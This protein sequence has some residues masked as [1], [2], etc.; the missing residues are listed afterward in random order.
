MTEILDAPIAQQLRILLVGDDAAEG[1][2][3]R[4][5]LE[6]C[7]DTRFQTHAARG[8]EEAAR[9]IKD[10]LFDAVLLDLSLPD[11]WG[12]ETLVRA[13]VMAWTVPVIVLVGSDQEDLA[14]KALRYGAQDFLIKHESDRMTVLRTLRSA[15]ERHRLLS[16][17]T[18]ARRREYFLANHDGLT[19]LPNRA[20]FQDQLGRVL[21]YASRNDKQLA[22]LFIDLNDFKRINDDLG[23]HVG[24]EILKAVGERV[25]NTVRRSD[26]S[27]RLGGDEFVV[28]AQDVLREG[29]PAV[30]A[31]KL[32]SALARPYLVGGQ[33]LSL[34]ASIG[35]AVFPRDGRNAATLI[36]HADA[37]MYRA[38][39]AG[40]SQYRFHLDE[41]HDPVARDPAGLRDDLEGALGRKEMVVHYERRV[42]SATGQLLAVE[43]LLRWRH[44]RRGL[45]DA[46]EFMP[47]AQG[48]G[49]L[50]QIGEWL[51]RRAC[52]DAMRWS[53]VVS[54]GVRVAVSVSLRQLRQKNFVATLK[55]CLRDSGLD[56]RRLE[57]GISENG[58]NDEPGVL[59]TTLELLRKL[60]VRVWIDDFGAGRF[61]LLDLEG[62]GAV[63]VK[64]DRSIVAGLGCDASKERVAEALIALARR[65]DLEV[66]AA[67]VES[68]E[69]LALLRRYGCELVQGALFGE[70]VPAGA[71]F[72]GFTPEPDPARAAPEGS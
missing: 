9:R 24:D 69:Q 7:D 47:A 60:G 37:A 59:R 35:I 29:D 46:E 52:E 27:A 30:V 41:G 4:Q 39:A 20:Y 54:R 11:A 32:V 42:H 8:F 56:A 51:L 22:I 36:R 61:S 34:S 50:L 49:V 19:G 18:L 66:G 10:E 55:G 71:S 64:L 53:E 3:L 68:A 63:G 13:R 5:L 15:I 70:P 33:E 43:A 2:R 23:H 38:K 72:E 12:E 28:V 26:L 67:G 57:I 40:P 25:A 31:E 17:L 14:F 1:K 44:P 45:L 48:S 21:A 6:S 62:T 58:V 16:E 65:L